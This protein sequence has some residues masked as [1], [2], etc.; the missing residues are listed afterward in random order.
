VAAVGYSAAAIGAWQV[1]PEDRVTPAVALV[2]VAMLL[3]LAL[4]QSLLLRRVAR[5]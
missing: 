1:R 4:V 3:L 2:F 5:Q